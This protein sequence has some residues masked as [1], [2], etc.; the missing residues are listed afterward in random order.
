MKQKISSLTI[1]AVLL[2]PLIFAK[3]GLGAEPLVLQYTEPATRWMEEALPIGNGQMGAM[4][5]GGVQQEHIQFNEESL[6]VGDESHS[7]AYQAFGDIF[8]EL[9]DSANPPNTKV[10]TPASYHRELDLE[11][12]VHTVSYEQNGIHYRRESFASYPAK[13]IAY[14]FTADKPGS[15]SGTVSLTDMHNS[16]ISAVND[17]ITAVGWLAGYDDRL[18]SHKIKPGATF[19]NP[20][21][22]P[23]LNFEAQVRV[24]HEGGTLK[25]DGNKI[26]FANASSITL[27]LSAGTDFLQDHSKQWQGEL[28]HAKVTARIEAA[29]SRSWNDLL[30]EHLRDYQNL[31]NRVSLDL[32]T[33]PDAALPTNIRLVNLKETQKR[34]PQLE[35]LLFQYGRYLTIASSR[36]GGLPANLQ[37][38]WNNSNTPAWNG[39]YHTDINIQMNY[40]ATDVAN[41]SECFEPYADW[42]QSIRKPGWLSKGASGLFGGSSQRWVPGPA[43]AWLLQNIYNHYRFTH[44][45]EYLRTRI[46]PVMKE[47]CDYWL[48]NLVAQPDG[49]L[50]TPQIFTPD[51]GPTEVGISFHMQVIWDLFNNTIE[52]STILGVDEDYR[53][54]LIESQSHLLAPKI[55]SLGQLQERLVER[56]FPAFDNDN[57]LHLIGLY[58]GRQISPLKTPELAEAARV[59]MKSRSDV[60]AGWSMANKINIWARLQ[61]GD[62]AYKLIQNLLNLV[63]DKKF[64]WER[65]GGV[66]ANLLHACPPF[67]ID[68]NLGYTAGVCE[69]L[70]QSHH[71]E[72]HLLPALPQAWANGSVKGLRARGGFIVDIE[73]KDGK[74]T[75]YRI[76][77]AAPKE[78]KVRVD[79]V[80]KTIRSAAL[81]G[82]RDL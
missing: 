63:G 19:S 9:A 60:S 76:T 42:V 68:G 79:G 37:G 5:F 41:L 33:S 31:F 80:L 43:S 13:V 71:D 82:M 51:Y 11:R 20:Y 52:A 59:A 48:A 74:L 58:P 45:K 23:P 69:M 40:W 44:G 72:I 54:L 4:L 15:L 64:K 77:S 6:W 35:T 8:V 1:A 32:G 24:L 39:D 29:A 53:K 36:Q 27:L 10:V 34:D 57:L 70:L 7:G 46:Y 75:G 38:K 26:V 18:R 49:T 81:P 78:V 50:V 55:G 16:D 22:K 14:R 25:L 12:A 73:W 65:G 17:T 61:D 30:A 56:G 3:P 47:V 62:H 2:S 66:H 21:K 67:Q 28:P